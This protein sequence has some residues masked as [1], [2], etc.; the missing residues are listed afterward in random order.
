[1]NIFTKFPKPWT[2]EMGDGEDGSGYTVYDADERTVVFHGNYSGDGDEEN[3]LS[4]SQWVELVVII[5]KSD[6]TK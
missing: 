4:Y 6:M 2:V 3:N 5:N 1:M